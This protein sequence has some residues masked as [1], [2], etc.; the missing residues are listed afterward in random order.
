M[1]FQ[2][3]KEF[4]G[5]LQTKIEEQDLSFLKEEILTLHPA[6]IA[7]IFSEIRLEEAKF[8]FDLLGYERS[9]L[10]LMELTEEQQDKLLSAYDSQF[11]ADHLIEH[12]ESDDAAYILS[13]LGEDKKREVLS[14][15]EDLEQASDLADILRYEEGTAGA[16]MAKEMIKV[17]HNWS[18]TECIKEM[19]KQAQEVERVRTIYV[20]DDFGKLLG[21]L[22]LKG[23]LFASA[24]SPIKKLYSAEIISV[25]AKQSREEVAKIMNK[26]DL[27]VLPVVDDINRLLGRITIDDV[28]DF[29]KEEADKDYQIASGYSEVVES[30][31]SVWT[32]SRSR[33]PWLLIGLLGG[34]L[35]S[36]VIA[37]YEE[38]LKLNPEM[39]FFIPLIA[40]MAGNAGVQSSAI[41]VQALAN[42]SLGL[43]GIKSKLWKEIK[44]S[45]ISGITCSAVILLYSMISGTETNLGLTVSIALLS[46]IIFATLF[47]TVTP[48][49]LNKY[50][51][52]P[53]IATGPFITTVNDIFGLFLYFVI[54]RL[55]YMP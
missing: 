12:L 53:A 9:A 42:Q 32:L 44:V 24:K 52:D 50:K 37:I 23:L 7:E 11:I 22:S 33:L 14:K 3:T 55:M 35:G 28:V 5:S 45:L 17:S 25:N 34:V 15:I 16:F 36:R 48:L 47:G 43:G 27:D 8:I 29:I 19:R 1:S 20:I 6:D 21:T 13:K 54:G 18:V 49:L 30:S 46:V 41:V 26:Y 38:E 51:I 10:V 40:A 31:D 2:L 4:I 39:A